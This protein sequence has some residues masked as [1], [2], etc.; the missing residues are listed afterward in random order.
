VKAVEGGR[1]AQVL[2][3][4]PEEAG[5][6]QLLAAG[7]EYGAFVQSETKRIGEILAGLNL[8]KK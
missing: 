8:G 7:D 4:D 5:L 6:G 3:R 2:G 1:E